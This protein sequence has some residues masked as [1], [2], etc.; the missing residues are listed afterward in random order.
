MR[1]L[2]LSLALIS[3]AAASVA[4]QK[5]MPWRPEIGI[6]SAFGKVN[7][8]DGATKFTVID[9]PGGSGFQGIGGNA[10][11]F[12]VIPVGTGRFAIEPG[13]GY[14]DQTAGGTTVSLLAANARLLFSAYRGVYL[15]AGPG[16]TLVKTNGQEGARWGGEVAAGYRF[17]VGG[18]VDAR[19][20]VFYNQH[21]KNDNIGL[22]KDHDIGLAVALGMGIGERS[23]VRSSRRMASSDRMWDLALGVQGGYTHATFP[24][25]IE[26]TSM[27]LPGTGGE[28]SLFGLPIPAV[29]PWFVQIPVG[30]RFAIEPSFSYHSFSLDGGTKG[31]AFGLGVRGDYAFN[32]T[33]YGAV[34]ADM[35]SVGGDLFT[36][37][38]G[39]HGFG[40][41]FGARYPLF[42]GLKGRTELSYKTFT[43]GNNAYLPDHQV[44]GLS[45][46]VVAPLK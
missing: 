36:G 6:R 44:T 13:L 5:P 20:E 34:S 22:P 4:A 19:A 42:A 25:Q 7:V 41:A 30:Q 40:V 12:A 29:N 23:M 45:F 11:L 31:H 27:S 46:G 43:G 24:G 21:G 33:L 17:H 15:A 28:L 37:A 9:I 32:R 35:S 3:G 1:K 39:I 8:D 26:I 2:G 38:D 10:S 18:A 14:S 16:V